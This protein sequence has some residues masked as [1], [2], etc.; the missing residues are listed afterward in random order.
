M[1]HDN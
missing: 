1:E